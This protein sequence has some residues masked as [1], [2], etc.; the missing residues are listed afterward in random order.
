MQFFDPP[1]A[2]YKNVKVVSL[3]A[4]SFDYNVSHVSG[5]PVLDA[6]DFVKLTNGY[7]WEP[8]PYGI[9]YNKTIQSEFLLDH[10]GT[11]S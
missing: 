8:S 3:N 10:S 2:G 4:N 5:S 1:V 7:N 6:G 11:R 9:Q